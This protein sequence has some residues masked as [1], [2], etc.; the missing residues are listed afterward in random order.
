MAIHRAWV[1]FVLGEVLE[2]PSEV[3]RAG[4]TLPPGLRVV[5]QQQEV[6][7]PDWAIV[8]PDAPHQPRMLVQMVNPEQGL[9]KPLKGGKAASA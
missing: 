7:L 2:L 8:E 6:L 4:Q 9:E 5:T 3:M 1:E